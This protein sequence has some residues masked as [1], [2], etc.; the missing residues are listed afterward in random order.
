MAIT[1]IPKAPSWS[2]VFL[3]GA[4]WNLLI[5]FSLWATGLCLLVGVLCWRF[6]KQFNR[7]G[8]RS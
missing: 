4:A 6:G 7:T 5:N 8:S 2:Q 1:R 3:F